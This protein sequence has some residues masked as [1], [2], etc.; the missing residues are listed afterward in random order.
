[1]ISIIIPTFCPGSYLFDCLS[2]VFNQTVEKQL[3]EVIIVLNGEKSPYYSLI[4]EY[5]TTRDNCKLYYS[6][7][8]GVSAARNLGLEKSC[9]EY[10]V[11]LDDDDL[12]SQNYLEDL[13]KSGNG[14]DIVV[15]NVYSFVEYPSERLNDYLTFKNHSVRVLENRSYLSNACCKLIPKSIIGNRRFNTKLKQG[16]DAVF[17]FSI[18]DKIDALLKSNKDC[19]YYRRLRSQSASRGKRSIIVKCRLILTLQWEFSK[20]YFS[21]PFRFNFLLYI[22]RLLAVLKI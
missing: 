8:Q 6:K 4:E 21:A 22:S 5:I 1:M 13:L 9:G 18:S 20:I 3:F 14:K 15:S 10:V 11:F 2:S 17:M 12:L 7:K 19:I 16:E